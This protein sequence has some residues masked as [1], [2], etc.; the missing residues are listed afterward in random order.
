MPGLYGLVISGLSIWLALRSVGRGAL[1]GSAGGNEGQPE[2]TS[3]LRLALAAAL[4]L[5]FCV[6]LIGR[7][8][9]WLAS[10][11]FV[12]AFIALFEW[13]PGDSV[14]RRT[15]NLGTALLQGVVTGIAVVLV[16]EKVFYVRL[17]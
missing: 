15:T 11:I 5:V 12:T 3:N 14:G 6:A 13:R 16:F 4:G 1:A 8:P 10:A 9:F 2:G 7:T 17:P